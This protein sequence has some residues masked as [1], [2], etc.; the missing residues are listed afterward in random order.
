MKFVTVHSRSV[1][2]LF[3]SSR[4]LLSPSGSEFKHEP[5]IKYIKA[6]NDTTKPQKV[7]NCLFAKYISITQTHTQTGK[8]SSKLNL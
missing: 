1:G 8:C 6:K 7:L 4:A 3:Y 5:L 2:L